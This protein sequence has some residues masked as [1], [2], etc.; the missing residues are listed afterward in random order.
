MIEDDSFWDIEG[1]ESEYK[2]NY[3]D[4]RVLSRTQEV[5]QILMR[6]DASGKPNYELLKD[7][8]VLATVKNSDLELHRGV[9]SVFHRVH[10]ETGDIQET[11]FNLNKAVICRVIH[12]THGRIITSSGD[13]RLICGNENDVL[14]QEDDW[15]SEKERR[16][17]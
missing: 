1:I 15:E 12:P 9:E 5:E 14:M 3:G 10:P 8:K 2:S 6:I 16:R 4:Y 11:I 13:K 17:F 7:N